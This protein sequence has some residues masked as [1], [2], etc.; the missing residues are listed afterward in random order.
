MNYLA[1]CIV[2][3]S[4]LAG[5]AGAWKEVE[6]NQYDELWH[7]FLD[8]A[9]SMSIKERI[10]LL[11]SVQVGFKQELD[12]MNRD[13]SAEY[14]QVIEDVTELDE[15]SPVQLN[16]EQLVNSHPLHIRRVLLRDRLD[17][18]RGLIPAYESALAA[19]TGEV[20]AAVE[21]EE[22]EAE[23]EKA[24]KDKKKRKISFG[25]LVPSCFKGDKNC[26]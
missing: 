5:L 2:L 16:I 14:K 22:V 7:R 25:K 13:D 4:C 17:E 23:E 11:K 12:R 18:I 6:E 26:S 10:E 3:A 19:Q 1:V 9:G 15:Q 24:K 20:R 21:E 8:S